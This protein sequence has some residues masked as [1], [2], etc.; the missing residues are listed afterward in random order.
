MKTRLFTVCVL[1]FCFVAPVYADLKDGLQAYY[2]FDDCSAKD[3]SGMNR[4]GTIFGAPVCVNG[5]I[6]KAMY[7]S[8]NQDYIETGYSQR[9][10]MSYTISVWVKLTDNNEGGVVFQNRGPL[11]QG[12]TSITLMTTAILPSDGNR[13]PTRFVADTDNKIAGVNTNTNINN[14]EW[15]HIVGTWATP[16]GS[17]IESGNFKLFIDGNKIASDVE[18][19]DNRI[20]SPINGIGK[21]LIGKHE[22][23]GNFF[24]GSIDEIRIYDRVLSD[25]E[26]KQLYQDARSG[27]G[28]V[29]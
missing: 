4:N 19:G 12:G 10:L 21:A 20:I 11:Y 7:F 22:A 8:G 13:Y 18:Q 6:G 2:C 16:S 14:N 27:S 1:F 9:N 3:T 29:K 24:R 28:K 23:W 5:K 15:H 26:I 25:I 17:A